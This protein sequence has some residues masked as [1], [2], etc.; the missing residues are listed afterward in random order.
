M[1]GIHYL[2][3][4]CW[5]NVG[6]RPQP[7]VTRGQNEEVLGFWT[8]G[9]EKNKQGTNESRSYVP[10]HDIP[11]GEKTSPHEKLDNCPHG[12]KPSWDRRVFWFLSCRLWHRLCRQV[13]NVTGLTA[14]YVHLRL[15]LPRLCSAFAGVCSA[16]EQQT[17]VSG[18]SISNRDSSFLN[19]FIFENRFSHTHRLQCKSFA[20]D[21]FMELAEMHT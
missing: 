11:R 12:Y 2:K 6:L 9:S 16:C 4:L 13:L 17:V 1:P 14:F 8:D 3:P 7:L 5:H 20:N 10:L 19:H 21:S 18:G 15:F